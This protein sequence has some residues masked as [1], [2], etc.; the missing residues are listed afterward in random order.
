[1]H[2]YYDV[3]SPE[4]KPEIDQLCR[5]AKIG[6]TDCKKELSLIMIKYLEPYAEKKRELLK[7]KKTLLDIIHQGE[8]KAREV[9]ANTISEVKSL[10]GIG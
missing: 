7:N 1:M 6:C 10:L 2:T 5:L 9:A 3:F 8:L 4:R